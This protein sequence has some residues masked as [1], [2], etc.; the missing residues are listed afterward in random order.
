MRFKVD[1]I[2]SQMTLE[3]RMAVSNR[4][5]DP[6]DKS[7]EILVCSY[8]VSS[9]GINLHLDCSDCVLFEPAVNTNTEIQAYGR[10]HRLGQ[11]KEQR[12]YRLSMTN[13]F[14]EYQEYRM[15]CKMRAEIAGWI[16][17]KEE[18]VK[19]LLAD[20]DD[21]PTHQ[22]LTR[23]SNFARA[24]DLIHSQLNG[25]SSLVVRNPSIFLDYSTLGLANLD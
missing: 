21:D 3:Q 1:T 23:P 9:L 8:R 13:S 17:D 10:L 18:I 16:G 4:F 14:N 11:E 12:I 20:S 6:E 22:D 24:V 15:L 2:L 5:N 7:I 19:E 25:H